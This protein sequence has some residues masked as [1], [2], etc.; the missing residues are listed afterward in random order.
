MILF[1]TC[2]KSVEVIHEKNKKEFNKNIK[3][4]ESLLKKK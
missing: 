3:K 1:F 4:I 2:F